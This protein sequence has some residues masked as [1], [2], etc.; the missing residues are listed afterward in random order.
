MSLY[1][2]RA[3]SLIIFMACILLPAF[4]QRATTCGSDPNVNGYSTIEDINLDMQEL[5][6]NNTDG[7]NDGTNSSVFTLCPRTSFSAESGPLVPLLNDTIILCGETGDIGD[8]CTFE[9]GDVQILLEGELR[10]V[11]IQGIGFQGFTGTSIA[12]Y[13]STASTVVFANCRWTVSMKPFLSS[14]CKCPELTN[15]AD[16]IIFRIS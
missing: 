10:N 14:Y 2:I 8:E 1:I 13:A 11:T 4:G 5:L 9:G 12:A 7:N 3:M 16:A 6:V 15:D